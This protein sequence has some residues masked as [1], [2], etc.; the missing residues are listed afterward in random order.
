MPNNVAA[1][2]RKCPD[3]LYIVFICGCSV[4]L[5]HSHSMDS[6]GLQELACTIYCNGEA[7]IPALQQVSLE[8]SHAR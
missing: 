5:Q 2:V 7:F 4:K 3:I 6:D 1:E 8:W